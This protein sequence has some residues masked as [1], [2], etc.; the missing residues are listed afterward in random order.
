MAPAVHT[1]FSKGNKASPLGLDRTGMAMKG[2]GLLS[3]KL[4]TSIFPTQ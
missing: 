4:A 3:V 2:T 1:S